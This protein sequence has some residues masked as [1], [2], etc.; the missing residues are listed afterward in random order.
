MADK[1]RSNEG[2]GNGKGSMPDT[3]FLRVPLSENDKEWLE[4]ADCRLE[5]P[6]D[7]L[8]SL[9]ATGY[10]VS[11]APDAKNNC[12]IATLT[13]KVPNSPTF[14]CCISSRGSSPVNAWYAL[15]YRH[16]QKLGETWDGLDTTPQLSD[17]G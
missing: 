12:F 9:V 8:F 2:R 11:L 3:V 15:A 7:L 10:K 13:D 17:F 4:K 6:P 14:N 16:F 1:K 5:F